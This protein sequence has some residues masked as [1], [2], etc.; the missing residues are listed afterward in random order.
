VG[1]FADDIGE[2]AGMATTSLLGQIGTGVARA[3]QGDLTFMGQQLQLTANSVPVW[4][5]CGGVG[6]L[7]QDRI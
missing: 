5:V 4:G 1:D 3:P 2:E 7:L 6:I